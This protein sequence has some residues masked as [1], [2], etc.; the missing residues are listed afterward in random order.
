MDQELKKIIHIDMDAFY[1]SVEQRDFP[2]L[3]GKP[4]AVGG[5]A[6]RGVIAAASY[7][8]RRFGI[9]SAM[10]SAIA[11]QKCRH[12]IFVPPRFSVYKAVSLQIREI[13]YQYTD[14]I[15]PLSLDEAFLDVTE[16]KKAMS[17]A[18][19]IA[20][21][22]RQKV[23]EQTHLTCS[24]GISM[25]KFLAKTASDIN[26][27]NGYCLIHPTQAEDFVEKLPVKKFFGIG[28]ATEERM[29]KMGIHTG[30]DLKAISLE[31]LIKSFGKSGKYYYN[32]CRA[33]DHRPVKP[34]RKAKSI[35]V[36]N[37]FTEDLE[38]PD[39]I[40]LSI[41]RLIADLDKRF[42]NRG[43]AYKTVV[44]KV[45]FN[46]FETISRNKS[47]TEY[48]TNIT[49]ISGIVS[50]LF[51][52]IERPLKPIRLLGVGVQ[53]LLRPEEAESRQLTFDF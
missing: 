10:P 30:K 5:S 20:N 9:H 24:A 27:P 49:P 32:I 34:D 25:N 35:S 37:T 40:H 43:I 8:A 4:V 45:R 51:E 12:L 33:I 13:F 42:Q 31:N 22:I 53:N 41:H 47:M 39:A 17:S 52:Q 1:A 23:F 21:E 15:E 2:E 46:D 3:M 7:E 18:T 44:L 19:M 36:E 29:K 38:Q 6:K 26:K 28:K 48:A 16:N 50:E 14:L 11:K